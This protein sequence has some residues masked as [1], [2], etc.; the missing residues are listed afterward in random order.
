MNHETYREWLALDLYDELDEGEA[1]RLRAHLTECDECQALRRDLA[2]T[3]GAHRRVVEPASDELPSDWV[4]RLR[5]TTEVRPVR[6]TRRGWSSFAAGLAAGLLVMFGM[7]ARP[8]RP[9]AP[10]PEAM[11]LL[12][13]S[14]ARAAPFVGRTEAPPPS[15]S[16][17]PLAHLPRWRDR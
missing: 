2:A 15:T 17:G 10:T 16:R 8:S 7:Q 3:L 12:A 5:A 9:T 4:E 13:A 6:A 14:N 11:L 1:A